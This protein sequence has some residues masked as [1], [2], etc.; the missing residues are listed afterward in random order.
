MEHKYERTEIETYGCM[1]WW[2]QFLELPNIWP[3]KVLRPVSAQPDGMGQLA[4]EMEPMVGVDVGGMKH[5]DS[6]RSG[7]PP[8]RARRA[9]K[10]TVMPPNPV[11]VWLDTD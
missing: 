9:E 3:E 6:V 11:Q 2:H 1:S 10:T 4:G 8:T 7:P 5:V